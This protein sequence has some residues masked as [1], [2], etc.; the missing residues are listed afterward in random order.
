MR[1]SMC[2]RIRNEDFACSLT[3]FVA[4]AGNSPYHSIAGLAQVQRSLF[5]V[6]A[7]S[8]RVSSSSPDEAAYTE[9]GTA[10]SAYL[11]QAAAKQDPASHDRQVALDLLSSLRHSLPTKSNALTEP[12]QPTQYR[13]TAG[14]TASHYD[15]ATKPSQPV[16]QHRQTRQTPPPE[17]QASGSITAAIDHAKQPQPGHSRSNNSLML[18]D[19]SSSGTDHSAK[20]HKQLGAVLA[21]A[22]AQPH[23]SSNSEGF[24]ACLDN[25]ELLFRLLFFQSE[26]AIECSVEPTYDN[27]SQCI[28]NI[29]PALLIPQQS[30]APNITG[31]QTIA[32][33]PIPTEVL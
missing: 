33:H 18:L 2:C 27:L 1:Q 12:L 4:T 24:H 3:D 9:P 22:Q 20:L 26:N 32:P 5:S 6:A 15:F 19:W 10:H 11:K 31:T 25:V 14:K 16:P 23:W 21:E 13:K 29:L 30:P 28:N 7:S 17:L 8:S